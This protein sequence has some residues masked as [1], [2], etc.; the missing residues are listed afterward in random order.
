MEV[1]CPAQRGFSPTCRDANVPLAFRILSHIGTAPSICAISNYSSRDPKKILA[2]YE[3]RCR[4]PVVS[5]GLWALTF[6]NYLNWRGNQKSS[7]WRQTGST[8][9]LGHD[10]ARSSDLVFGRGQ[11]ASIAYLKGLVCDFASFELSEAFS[12]VI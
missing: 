9:W 12:L 4:A 2:N 1:R 10:L 11:R 5:R 6:L 8:W 3:L 7:L